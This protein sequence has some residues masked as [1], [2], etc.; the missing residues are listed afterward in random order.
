[1]VIYLT[2][3]RNYRCLKYLQYYL[4]WLLVF[5]SMATQVSLGKYNLKREFSFPLCCRVRP[6]M[7]RPTCTSVSYIIS[8]L[9]D[10]Y[11]YLHQMYL[12]DTAGLAVAQQNNSKPC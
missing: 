4:L 5:I 8:L 2:L 3:H 12:Q 11:R 6:H 10:V 1:M 7:R 9:M